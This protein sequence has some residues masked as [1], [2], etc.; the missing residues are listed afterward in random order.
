M[1]TEKNPKN[2]HVQSVTHPTM[3]HRYDAPKEKDAPTAM[4]KAD[5]EFLED[6]RMEQNE[7]H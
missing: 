1:S 3:E 6:L 7:L 4:S 5:R 2:E